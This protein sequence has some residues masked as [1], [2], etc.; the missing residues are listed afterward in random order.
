[1]IYTCSSPGEEPW[2][3]A[4]CCINEIGKFSLLLTNRILSNSSYFFTQFCQAFRKS[5]LLGLGYAASQWMAPREKVG[6]GKRRKANFRAPSRGTSP[7]RPPEGVLDPLP[8][9][10][11][12][13]I[14][15][16]PSRFTARRLRRQR[17][18]WRRG[19][20]ANCN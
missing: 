3:T 4:V 13:V 1:M 8:P 6:D 17:L 11:G 12:H 7:H 18:P 9:L 19:L 20:V 16:Q 15:V 2:R 10:S 14:S 5:E